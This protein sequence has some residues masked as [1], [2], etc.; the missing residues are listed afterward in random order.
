M[1]RLLSRMDAYRYVPEDFSIRSSRGGLFSL[2]AFTLMIVLLFCELYS[3]M[4]PTLKT[5]IQMDDNDEDNIELYFDITML[6]LPCKF[7]SVDLVDDFGEE[8]NNVTANIVKINKHWR[9]GEL[10]EGGLH[11]DEEAMKEIE[12]EEE[13]DR[14]KEVDSEGH[15]ALHIPGDQLDKALRE[16]HMTFINFYAPWCHWCKRLEPHWEAAATKFD[17]MKFSH[18]NLHVKFA[19]IDCEAHND[20]C[21]KYRVRAFP[22][23]LLFKRTEAIY[24]FYEGDRTESA[25]DAFFE[26]AV[27]DYEK[28]MP[29][30]YKNEA[31][32]VVGWLTVARVPGNFHIEAKSKTHDLSP[33]MAN[34]S[35]TINHLS[36]GLNVPP[37]V[38]K[39]LE[40]EHKF[41]TAPLNGKTFLTG[42]AHESPTHFMKIVTV[43]LDSY[44]TFPFYEMTSQNRITQ[45][46]E[47]EV[48]EARFVF[49]FSPLAITIQKESVRWYTFVTSLLA[50]IGGSFTVFQLFS[51]F[52]GSLEDGLSRKRR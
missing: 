47:E 22:S 38:K 26:N 1:D 52:I 19:S 18:K 42:K 37:A 8:T 11:E 25:L 13:Y 6:D 2:A 27:H 50:L 39:N 16:H 15:H 29:N 3:F 35:H 28:H 36:F 14:T 21:T 41:L 51:G 7:V 12:E 30:A 40:A 5:L 49:D 33:V 44:P 23:L 46:E 32:Q 48:P 34:L 31:C 17:S 10:I 43:F 4:T 20:V 24:P 9:R 45:Y